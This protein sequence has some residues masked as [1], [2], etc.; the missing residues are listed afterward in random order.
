MS[1][2]QVTPN[3]SAQAQSSAS[4][5]GLKRTNPVRSLSTALQHSQ[6]VNAVGVTGA[7]QS[8]GNSGNSGNSVSGTPPLKKQ[9]N[10]TN[11][12]WTIPENRQLMNWTA[13]NLPQVWLKASVQHALRIKNAV[14]QDNPQ[15]TA[16]NI[17]HKINNI[18]AKYR[19][20]RARWLDG[21]DESFIPTDLKSTLTRF[22]SRVAFY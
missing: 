11:Y 4:G 5:L 21:K 6:A 18:K 2:H 13:A 19:K 10:P 22:F 1:A 3:N 8:G 15:I 20:V 16:E 12:V 7:G 17:R 9:R 14:Y